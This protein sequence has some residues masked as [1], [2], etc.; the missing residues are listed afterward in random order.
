LYETLCFNEKSIFFA[1][2]IVL[3]IFPFCVRAGS[4]LILCCSHAEV[5]LLNPS[6]VGF[7]SLPLAFVLSEVFPSSPRLRTSFFVAPLAVLRAHEQGAIVH[8]PAGCF[9]IGASGP[10]RYSV[11][12][13]SFLPICSPVER[14]SSCRWLFF[15][16]CFFRSDFRFCLHRLRFMCC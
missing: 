8:S 9:P 7:W 3:Y 4:G 15:V 2:L 13:V 6:A 1:S 12:R 14:R 11:A 16:R 5:F 10:A